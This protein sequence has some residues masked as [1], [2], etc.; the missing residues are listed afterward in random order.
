MAALGRFLPG[1]IGWTARAG[2]DA[3]A[4][5]PHSGTGVSQISVA[6]ALTFHLSKGKKS[7]HCYLSNT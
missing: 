5:L 4:F 6:I 2:R 1:V 3:L 7:G